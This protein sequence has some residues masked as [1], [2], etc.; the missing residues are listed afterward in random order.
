MFRLCLCLCLLPSVLFAADPALPV[1]IVSDNGYSWMIQDSNGKPVLY[2][3]AQVIII[4]KPTTVPQPP[5][6]TP[7]GLEEPIRKLVQKLSATSKLDLPAV[8]TGIADTA[9]MAKEGKFK[10][11]GEVEAVAAALMKAAIKDKDG[12]K[13]L[14]VAIDTSLVKLQRDG[15]ITTPGQY[16]NALYEIMNA[17][18]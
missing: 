16:A 14:A 10:Q 1:L 17:M 13:E 2:E 6:T 8:R 5:A 4:G 7:Y 9:L 12:W 3:F 18:Q 11:L 15:K